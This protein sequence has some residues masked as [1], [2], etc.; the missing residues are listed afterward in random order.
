MLAAQ[1]TVAGDVVFSGGHFLNHNAI[2]FCLGIEIE[3]AW[4]GRLHRQDGP[5]MEI[6][7]IHSSQGCVP[8]PVVHRQWDSASASRSL[9]LL[10]LAGPP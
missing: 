5:T 6:T 1:L 3:R 9:A 10:T 2:A 7:L 8:L 4:R